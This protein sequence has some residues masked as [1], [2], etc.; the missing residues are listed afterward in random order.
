MATRWQPETSKGE[1]M[2]ME[3]A[4]GRNNFRMKLLRSFN[5]EKQKGRLNFAAPAGNLKFGAPALKVVVPLCR[6]T[7][8][9]IGLRA[10]VARG[11]KLGPW[12]DGLWAT[13]PGRSGISM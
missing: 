2:M 10:A 4:L 9:I 12:T 11:W 6:V 8:F 1:M 13:W 3:A 7:R 5:D